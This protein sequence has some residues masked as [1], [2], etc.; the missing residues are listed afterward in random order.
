MSTRPPS[1]NS[2]GQRSRLRLVVVQALVLSL[3]A[4]LFVRLW[5]LQV[6]SGDDYRA[7]P[8]R[9]PCA[10]SWSSPRGLIVDDQG[11]PLVANRSSWVVS[12]TARPAR[13]AVRGRRTSCCRRR[14]G[15]RAARPRDDRRLLTAAT[16]AAVAAPAG[17]A[18]PTSRSPSPTTSPAARRPADP[19]A[20]RGLPRRRGAGAERARLP[21]PVRRQRRPRPGLPQ[22]DHRG[23]ARRRREENDLS[24]NGASE[25]GRAGV[26]KEYDEYLRGMPGYQHVAVDSM[27]RVLGDD[28]DEAGAARRHP[29]HLDRRQGPGRRRAA[30]R[31]RDHRPPAQ[32]HRPSRPATTSPTPAPSW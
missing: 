6:V 28:G 7:R 18:R 29:G 31:R 21:A 27:G 9:S 17:T 22:P 23:R 4:T 10:R 5:Y 11:R 16:P 20:A 14:Q 15:S 1:K 25:V 26:E 12:S 3:F 19:R 2:R 30:A 32:T 24:V 8:P 13:Q